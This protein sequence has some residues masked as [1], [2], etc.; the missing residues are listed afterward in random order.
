MDLE[1]ELFLDAQDTSFS[2]NNPSI[3]NN[4]TNHDNND[5]PIDDD[6]GI[7][8]TIKLANKQRKQAKIDDDRLLNRA[9]GIPYIIKNYSKVNRIIKNHDKQLNKTLINSKNLSSSQKK[10]LKIENEF[11]NF[12][13][14]LQFY[15]LWCH[16][17][18]PKANFKDCISMIRNFGNKPNALK[19]YRRSL[20]DKALDDYKREHGIIVESEMPIPINNDVYVDGS[21]NHNIS[22]DDD[23][24]YTTPS[25]NKSNGNDKEEDIHN[26]DTNN[27]DENEDNDSYFAFMNVGKLPR[28]KLFIADD[29]DDDDDDVQIDNNDEEDN[30][31]STKDKELINKTKNDTEISY[32]NNN[33]EKINSNDKVTNKSNSD[34]NND[35]T[36]YDDDDDPF[37]DMDDDE[38]DELFSKQADKVKNNNNVNVNP[39][40]E[41]E[42]EQ[43]QLMREMGW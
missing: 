33:G 8:Q 40:E 19:I 12:E 20:I 27:P 28:N 11:K 14:I 36:N 9:N 4:E 21:T 24:L 2:G 18:F 22:D 43:L 37:D 23:D 32:D 5:N 7:D 16:G 42:D 13:S 34:L 35:N 26:N 17:L 30:E 10:S 39:E 15:Q 29:D 38:F 31:N 25:I 1:E 6:L 41:D 3:T